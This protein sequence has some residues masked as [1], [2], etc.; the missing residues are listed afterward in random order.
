LVFLRIFLRFESI[1]S[2]TGVI[3]MRAPMGLRFLLAT[4]AANVVLDGIASQLHD[5]LHQLTVKGQAAQTR[6]DQATHW[7]EHEK[8]SAE[9]LAMDLEQRKRQY[10][11]QV[12]HDVHKRE[13]LLRRSEH[14]HRELKAAEEKIAGLSSDRE[15]EYQ[16]YLDYSPPN[17]GTFDA[18]VAFLRSKSRAIEAPNEYIQRMQR[19]NDEYMALAVERR[20]TLA[21][22]AQTEANLSGL[23]QQILRTSFQIS[24]S[25]RYVKRVTNRHDAIMQ[26]GGENAAKRKAEFDELTRLV[27]LI[28]NNRTHST[29]P[30]DGGNYVSLVQMEQ[31]PFENILTRL[32][33]LIQQLDEDQ[34]FEE[35]HLQWCK[36]NEEPVAEALRTAKLHL[37][38]SIS[39]Q[40]R[41]KPIEARQLQE[42]QEMV[43]RV[44]DLT[45]RLNGLERDRVAAHQRFDAKVKE[46]RTL[47]RDVND[48]RLVLERLYHQILLNSADKKDAVTVSVEDQPQNPT[49]KPMPE[50]PVPY[51]PVGTNLIPEVAKVLDS[52]VSDLR[53]IHQTEDENITTFEAA[54]HQL[55]TNLHEAREKR[56]SLRV[57][58]AE[59]RRRLRKARNEATAEARVQHRQRQRFLRSCHVLMEKFS[60]RTETRK[61]EHHRYEKAI[62]M[63]M[64]N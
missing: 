12:H 47:R 48:I 34:Q 20:R 22:I 59:T 51:V 61:E 16:K 30:I 52:I 50:I 17:R 43:L 2:D 18:S 19:L 9:S 62:R 1:I 14:L 11:E 5:V 26:Q 57:S 31:S 56:E 42:L 32:K 55:E 24:D 49:E 8:R 7:F 33:K 60:Q 28:E 15:Q 64:A 39:A 10:E 3:M 23:R 35:D 6:L 63:L 38:D 21:E 37:E 36:D 45:I 27:K 13:D 41:Q 44:Q 40:E 4:A 29:P 58:F 46:L 53:A 54:K 25:L